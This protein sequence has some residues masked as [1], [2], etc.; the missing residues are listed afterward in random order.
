MFYFQIYKSDSVQ[1]YWIDLEN[2]PIGVVDSLVPLKEFTNNPKKD[3]LPNS[4]KCRLNERK[5]LIKSNKHQTTKR[6][7]IKQLNKKIKSHFHNA[8]A[9]KVR[10]QV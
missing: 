1:D 8:K 2:Q 4:I 6:E 10:R 5:R 3:P 9:S 7:R